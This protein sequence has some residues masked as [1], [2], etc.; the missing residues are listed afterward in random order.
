[1]TLQRPSSVV[2]GLSGH[3]GLPHRYEQKGLVGESVIGVVGDIISGA[4]D[5][6]SRFSVSI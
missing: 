6:V 3:T 5:D 2:T 1:M 4:V